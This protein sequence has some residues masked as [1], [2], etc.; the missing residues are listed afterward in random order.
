[1]QHR[2]SN[3]IKIESCENCYYSR[4]Y[5]EDLRCCYN[6]PIVN[7]KYPYLSHFPIMRSKSIKWCGKYMPDGEPKDA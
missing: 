5:K 7:P 1:M 4:Y 2:K 6:S 3:A